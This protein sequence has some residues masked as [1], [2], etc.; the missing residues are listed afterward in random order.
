MKDSYKKFFSYALLIIA[1][2]VTLFPVLYTLSA[3][4]KTNM[5]ILTEPARLI[6]REFSFDN[7][8]QAWTSEEFNVPRMLTNSIYYTVISVVITLATCAMSG[9]VFARGEFPGKKVVFGCFISLMFIQTTS[10]TIYPKFEILNFLHMDK[11]LNSLLFLQLFGIPIANMYL[12][13]GF[14]ESLPKELDEA[15]AIDGCSFFGTF[16]KVILPLL[17]PSLATIGILSFN[18]SWNSYLMPAIFTTTKPEQQTLMIGLMA[19]KSSSGAATNWSLMMAGSIIALLPVLVA[20]A[21]GNKYFVDGIAAGAV[22][23]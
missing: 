11:G 21:F 2:A 16:V 22:K 18:G 13:R 14:V 4:F 9:Y 19:L 5:E 1:V 15:A 20:Y 3:S 6:P 23:G 17:K 7:Y 12:V 10:I 8:I